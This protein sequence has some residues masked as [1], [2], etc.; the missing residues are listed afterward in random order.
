MTK[1]P[2]KTN[3]EPLGDIDTTVKE[4]DEE[5][6]LNVNPEVIDNDNIVLPNIHPE[7][8]RTVITSLGNV[9]VNDDDEDSAPPLLPNVND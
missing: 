7:V 4:S 3:I 9:N 1:K 5:L 8:T 2:T 6:S